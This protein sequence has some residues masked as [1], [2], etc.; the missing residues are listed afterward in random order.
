MRIQT[1]LAALLGV[2]G[3]APAA[4]GQQVVA[5]GPG[6]RNPAPAPPRS[7]CVSGRSGRQLAVEP[8]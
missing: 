7:A 8:C 1:A 5:V 4:L 3:L 6:I 2:L